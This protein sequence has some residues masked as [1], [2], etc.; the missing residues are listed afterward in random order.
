MKDTGKTAVLTWR[1]SAVLTA[2]SSPLF[3]VTSPFIQGNIARENFEPSGK[4]HLFYS[5][6]ETTNQQG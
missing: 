6:G 2:I 4:Y 1:F 3:A 5:R